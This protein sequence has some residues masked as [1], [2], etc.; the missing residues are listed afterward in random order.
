MS[1]WISHLAGMGL[2]ISEPRLPQLR[3][4]GKKLIVQLRH[5]EVGCSWEKDARLEVIK[6]Q[7]RPGTQDKWAAV[8]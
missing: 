6:D 2:F 3:N 8:R 4:A 5:A 1:L 7:G